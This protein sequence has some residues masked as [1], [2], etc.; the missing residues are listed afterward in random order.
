MRRARSLDDPDAAASPEVRRRV[1][2][3]APDLP[4]GPCIDAV[5][6]LLDTW[7]TESSG[8]GNRRLWAEVLR[9]TCDGETPAE[10]ASALGMSAPAVSRLL[11]KRIR[12]AVK[13]ALE[14]G[15]QERDSTKQAD[16]GVTRS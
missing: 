14:R 15:R 16:G 13:S 7:E 8:R 12:P 11:S 6:Q 10:I 3:P 4:G 5:A 9:R 2:T 1:A